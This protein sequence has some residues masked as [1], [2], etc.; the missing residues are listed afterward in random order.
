MGSQQSRARGGA[1]IKGKVGAGVGRAL[2]PEV[3]ALQPRDKGVMQ[4]D[5]CKRSGIRA[6]MSHTRGPASQWT[7][8]AINLRHAGML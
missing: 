8:I 6:L 5:L 2:W 3:P 4:Y 1:G 7:I